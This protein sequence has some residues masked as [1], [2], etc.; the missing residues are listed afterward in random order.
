MAFKVLNCRRTSVRV[1]LNDIRRR[2]EDSGFKLIRLIH[3]NEGFKYFNVM[4]FECEK[5]PVEDKLQW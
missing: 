2:T 5:T 4:F 3:K 1:S